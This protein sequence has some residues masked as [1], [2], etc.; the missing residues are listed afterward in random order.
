MG[1]GCCYCSGWSEQ[2]KF[3]LTK[4]VQL[5][6]FHS[7]NHGVGIDDQK[8][9]LRLQL[10][11]GNRVRGRAHLETSRGTKCGCCCCCYGCSVCCCCCCYILALA[12]AFVVATVADFS[13]PP[14]AVQQRMAYRGNFTHG[15]RTETLPIARLSLSPPVA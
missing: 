14:L 3:C 7:A 6:T 15:V 8:L 11:S 9:R 12:A 4:L 5:P 2:G 10:C 13:P 1:A